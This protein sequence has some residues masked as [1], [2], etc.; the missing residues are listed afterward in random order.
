MS[1]LEKNLEWS[2]LKDVP[3]WAEPPRIGHYKESL[4]PPPPPPSTPNRRQGIRYVNL[5]TTY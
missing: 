1:K 5:K 4:P 3:F 2:I